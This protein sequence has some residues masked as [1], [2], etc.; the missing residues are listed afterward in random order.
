MGWSAVAIPT[1][2]E[3]LGTTRSAGGTQPWLETAARLRPRR[4]DDAMDEP[5]SAA[6]PTDR[7]RLKAV[8]ERVLSGFR[9]A[10]SGSD[11]LVAVLQTVLA[12]E[13]FSVSDVRRIGQPIVFVS[14]GF[15]ALTGFRREEAVGRDLGFLMRADTD[16]DEAREVREAVR[17]GRAATALVRCYRRD[18]SL[19]WNE[20]RHYPVKD[21]HGRVAHLVVVQRDV[22]ELVHA[23]SAH[24]V[25][26]QL[27]SSLGGEGAFFSYGA[28]LD[29]DGGSRIGWAHESVAAV[30]G[31]TPAEL[32][33][34]ELLELIVPEDREAARARLLAL[35]DEGGSRRD[36]YRMLNAE[37]RVRWVEDFAAVSWS[38]KEAGLVAIHGV[39]RDV[40]AER[41]KRLE[42]GGVD[43]V[44][45]LPTVGVL[46]DR[47]DQAIRQARRYGGVA[48]LVVV[49]L[50]H[51]DFVHRT[52]DPRRAERLLREAARR[53]QRAL[54]RSDTLALL[55]ESCFAVVLPDLADAEAAVPVVEKLLAWVA[56]PF[57]DGS[58][59]VELSAS[60]GVALA[61]ADGRRPEV[62]RERAEFALQRARTAGGSRFAFADDALERAAE[63]R[64][65][66]ERELRRAFAENQLVLHYQPRIRFS[67]ASTR[68]VEALVRW[69]HP[70]RGLLLPDE[71]L[72]GLYRARMGDTLF[73]WV[74]EQAV[75]QAAA[76]R[77]CGD[78]RRVSVNVGPETLVH[79]EFSQLVR[80][81]LE[82]HQLHPGLLELELHENTGVLAF[83]RGVDQ[84]TAVRRHG[85]T[86]ALDDFGTAATNLTQLRLL[87]VDTL[88]IDR[89]FVARVGDGADPG[90][91]EL[92]RAM[93]GI[94]HGL[95]LCVVA[96]GIETTVQRER[97]QAMDVDEGQGFLFSHAVP[98][99][100]IDAATA[101]PPSVLR[102]L[103]VPIRSRP[104]QAS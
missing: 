34:R 50:D 96:E 6:M 54:R 59:R 64:I 14:D 37:G 2:W 65:D 28:I 49:E 23:R 70:E 57:E 51:F 38:A 97:V 27:A 77:E 20:Q 84:L 8:R 103:S 78:T 1:G 95:G 45:G 66:F 63:A 36:R 15:Q 92:L 71:F 83:E 99:E 52:M 46:V 75:A 11:E 91:V 17:E 10:D 76:W 85:V 58:L 88:K 48:G 5:L 29:G 40:S 19:F 61:P 30:L 90:D 22:T 89:S 31:F 21:P 56:R 9:D 32:H 3:A 7:A 86:V 69:R 87:P 74:L 43:A 33:E 18:G 35:R 4:D 26:R 102:S 60:A 55:R 100:L 98:A 53:L 24:E 42:V 41:L 73:E 47:L 12:G 80:S 72:A 93:V 68:A 13:S 39:V 16:Q 81:A 82:R 25:A 101:A 67:D 62:L 44:T 104:V 94:G 79:R